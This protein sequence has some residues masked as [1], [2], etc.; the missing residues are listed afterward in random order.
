MAYYFGNGIGE[1]TGDSLVSSTSPFYTRGTVYWVH[2]STGSDSNDG[3]ERARPLATLAQAITNATDDDV[4]VLMSGHS[5]TLTA[6]QN[7]AERLTIVGAGTS[8]GVPTVTFTRNF[9]GVMF[10]ITAAHVSLRNIKFAASATSSASNKITASGADL[11][12]IGCYFECADNDA[13]P[14]LSL[15][16]D[17]PVIEST[18]FISTGV[19]TPPYPALHWAT[20][21]AGIWIRDCIC[22]GGTIGF[23][24]SSHA[25]SPAIDGLTGEGT[26][27]KIEGTSCRNGADVL[28]FANGGWAQVSSSG[29]G[30]GMVTI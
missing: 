18:T 10:N 9:N 14:S 24:H 6:Q 19:S 4:I 30:G 20:T 15:A 16:A 28:V 5:E 1:S 2:S 23:K 17:Y 22:D 3:T 27:L 21:R 13:G 8:G 7:I 11:S 12:V 26:A 25:G 29:S